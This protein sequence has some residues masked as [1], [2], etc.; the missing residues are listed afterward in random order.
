ME[1]NVK[2]ENEQNISLFDV[3]VRYSRYWKWFLFSVVFFVAVSILR[4]YIKQREYEV[5]LYIL[6]NQER[7]LSATDVDYK[8]E[9]FGIYPTVS[10]LDNEMIVLSSPDLMTLVVDALHLDVDYSIKNAFGRRTYVYSESPYTVYFTPVDNPDIEMEMSIR[11]EALFYI[12][13]GRSLG[14]KEITFHKEIKELPSTISL[15]ENLG[16]ISVG[17]SGEAI[18]SDVYYIRVRRIPV[19]AQELA[20][21]LTITPTSKTSSVLKMDLQTDHVEKGAAV[22]EELI[23]QYNESAVEEKN[24]KAYNTSIFIDERLNEISN[25]LENIENEVVAYKQKNKITN[26]G[27]ETDLYVKQT[28]ENEEKR[29]ELET[30]LRI[31]TMVEDFVSNNSGKMIPGVGISD[32]NL[33]SAIEIYN[34]TLLSY[35]RL[36]KS[37]S[38]NNPSRIR[39]WKELEAARYNIMGSIQNERNSIRIALANINLHNASVGSRIESVPQQ[40]RNLL[41]KERQQQVIEKL[42]LFLMQKKEESNIA[43]VSAS[44][45]AKVIISPSGGVLTTPKTKVDIFTFFILGLIVPCLILFLKESFRKTFSDIHDFK[46]FSDLSIIGGIIHD[47]TKGTAVMFSGETSRSSELFRLLRNNIDYYFEHRANKLILV[48]SS[49]ENEGK[50][51]IS[52]N[53]AIAFALMNKRVMLID[54][55]MRKANLSKYLESNSTNG[56][57][58]YLSGETERW[59]AAIEC[60]DHFPDLHILKTGTEIQYPNELLM[61]DLFARFVN[62]VKSKYDY[63]IMDSS[64]IED[65]S[66]TFC[67]AERADMTLFVVRERYTPKTKISYIDKENITQR[68]KNL[69]VVFNDMKEKNAAFQHVYS[70]NTFI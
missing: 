66:D 21:K 36:L 13:E 61:S 39:L 22:L 1:Y 35:E 26:I 51:F 60:M 56:L 58:K 7:P 62:D 15:P 65:V 28:G 33:A 52:L 12:I 8:L 29:V 45:K 40:E 57:I 55:D 27:F 17:L 6:L 18:L 19:V 20:S 24:Q 38:E 59:E 49:I 70:D 68:L 14:G 4:S 64:S 42:F 3:I 50:S 44:E 30:Q 43:M 53:L 9:T 31:I 2:P 67:I 25:E 54:V 47:S 46:R 63:V 41:E 23:R 34:N 69:H 37:T 11:K 48:T 5:S 10:N 16:T 32:P